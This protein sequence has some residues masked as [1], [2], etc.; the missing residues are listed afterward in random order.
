[1]TLLRTLVEYYVLHSLHA[2]YHGKPSLDPI[3]GIPSAPSTDG[4]TYGEVW[5]LWLENKNVVNGRRKQPF[6]DITCV[7]LKVNAEDAALIPR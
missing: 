3:Y 1:M 2:N 4:R 5:L 6:D 7:P